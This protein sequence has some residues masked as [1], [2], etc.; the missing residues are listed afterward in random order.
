[1]HYFSLY[2]RHTA[3]LVSEGAPNEYE[4]AELQHPGCFSQDEGMMRS[5]AIQKLE[6]VKLNELSIENSFLYH[7][8]SGYLTLFKSS[9]CT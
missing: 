6:D 2:C 9:V 8:V 3:W 7:K 1:M 5:D 4:I